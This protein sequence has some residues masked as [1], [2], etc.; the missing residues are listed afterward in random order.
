MLFY[1]Q[2]HL[3]LSLQG[4][5]LRVTVSC[6][7]KSSALLLFYSNAFHFKAATSLPVDGF[8]RHIVVASGQDT[9]LTFPTPIIE[10]E[11]EG[12]LVQNISHVKVEVIHYGN[13]K[14]KREKDNSVEG[15]LSIADPRFFATARNT[16][17]PLSCASGENA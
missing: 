6:L 9:S 14:R 10:C 17:T 12:H 5:C 8:V 2:T 16:L 7:F 1:L 11:Q 4:L 13:H 3:Q 15:Y